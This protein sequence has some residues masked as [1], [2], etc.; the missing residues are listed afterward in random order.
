MVRRSERDRDKERFWR[1]VLRQWRRSGL[2]IRAFCMEHG[3]A[4]PS[5]YAW[6]RIIAE[7]DQQ[8]DRQ[9][10]RDRRS[11]PSRRRCPAGAPVLFVPVRVAASASL[12]EVVLGSGR[13]VRVPAGFDAA[14]LRLLLVVLEEERPC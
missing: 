9:A 3:L 6:R 2:T 5:F 1:R 14:T 10:N 13:V 7:R 8:A 4:E 11:R 12:L